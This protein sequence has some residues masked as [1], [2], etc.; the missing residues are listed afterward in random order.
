MLIVSFLSFEDALTWLAFEIVVNSFMYLQLTFPYKLK[1]A[2]FTLEHAGLTRFGHMNLDVCTKRVF[3]WKSSLTLTTN[4][5][6]IQNKLMY[7]NIYSKPRFCRENNN[8]KRTFPWHLY[9][10]FK[11]R[12]TFKT[13]A[14]YTNHNLIRV[15]IT[16]MV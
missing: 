12:R 8:T 6:L 9:T 5:R 1:S 14:I 15:P 13:I 16:Q 3:C 7:F 4:R 2:L 11:V 10:C